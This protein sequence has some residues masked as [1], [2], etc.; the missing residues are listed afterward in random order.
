MKAIVV[1]AARGV[2][3]LSLDEVPRPSMGSA[4]V[5]VRVRAAGL[6]RADLLQALGRYPAPPSA[7][8]D[9]L[10]LEYAG[11]VIE[12]GSRVRRFR[13]GDRVMGLTGGG[14][15]AEELVVHERETLPVP[16]DWTYVQAAA[17]PESFFTA[18]DALTLQGGLKRSDA[19]LIHAVT[20]GVGTAALQI[21]SARGAQVLGTGRSAQR[22]E[23]CAREVGLEH[24]IAVAE[25]G[26]FADRVIALT[27][28]RGADLILDL[29]GGPYL[30]E[31]V[32]AAAPGGRILAVG[33][34]GGSRSDLDLGR[35]L[36]RR[37][38]LFGTVLRSR[39]LEEKIAL[40]QEVDRELGPLWAA[41]T[42]RPRVACVVPWEDF[43]Q[44]FQALTHPQGLGKVVL[45]LE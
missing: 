28:G 1:K 11:E 29:I 33:L 8:P 23:A 19:V 22:L 32:R 2:D 41:G 17:A 36:Q 6:N 21:A 13:S 10:G 16:A 30:A 43:P 38:R 20:G 5:R 40:A 35:L 37:L 18:Y 15:F 12:A 42:L 4:E 45:T 34:L 39:P 31:S 24:P 25:D 7:P 3:G 27:H 9:G 26:S 14:A 44:A